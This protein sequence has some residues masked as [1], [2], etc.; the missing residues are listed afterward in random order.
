MRARLTV[1]ADYHIPDLTDDD[2]PTL[3]LNLVKY[4]LGKLFGPDMKISLT[5]TRNGKEEVLKG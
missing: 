2:I 3:E 1:E 5:V 4:E